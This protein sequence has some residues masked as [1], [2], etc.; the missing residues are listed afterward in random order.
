MPGM[1]DFKDR[2]G[3]LLRRRKERERGQALTDVSRRLLPAALQEQL[4]EA[5]ERERAAVLARIEQVDRDLELLEGRRLEALQAMR[6]TIRPL[7]SPARTVRRL[8]GSTFERRGRVG[9]GVATPA[10]AAANQALQRVLEDI[11]ARKEERAYRLSELGQILRIEN[12]TRAGAV[13]GLLAIT[14]TW[15]NRIDVGSFLPA[16]KLGRSYSDAAGNPLPPEALDAA[17]NPDLPQGRPLVP[18]E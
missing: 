13:S 6:A 10:T 16:A 18:H 1:K 5:C 8:D 3:V 11:A 17:G 9:V 2:F 14:A 7:A 4:L 12:Q 15:R